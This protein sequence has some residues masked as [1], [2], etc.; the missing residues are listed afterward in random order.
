MQNLKEQVQNELAVV[1]TEVKQMRTEIQEVK[2]EL[3]HKLDDFATKLDKELAEKD[4]FPDDRANV[5]EYF[6]AFVGTFS[7]VY[8]TSQIIDK[9]PNST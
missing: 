9:W 5:K 4:L 6:K 1:K 7:S 3:D 2:E 8:V